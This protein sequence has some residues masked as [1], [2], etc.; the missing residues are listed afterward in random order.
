MLRATNQ[1]FYCIAWEIILP[2]KNIGLPYNQHVV[3]AA[4]DAKINKIVVTL[5]GK[6]SN[7]IGKWGTPS[8]CKHVLFIGQI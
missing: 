3:A 4:A 8:M 5:L 6:A 1:Y 7:N 2:D